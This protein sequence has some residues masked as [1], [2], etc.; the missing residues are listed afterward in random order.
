MENGAAGVQLCATETMTWKLYDL[1]KPG[2]VAV[3]GYR[4][5]SV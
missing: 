1:R 3:A 5:L 4:G 2:C